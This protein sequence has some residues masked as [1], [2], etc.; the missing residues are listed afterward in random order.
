[1]QFRYFT[2]SLEGF[3]D[4]LSVMSPSLRREVCLHNDSVWINQVHML[5]GTG[6][7]FRVE[8]RAHA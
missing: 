1:V 6:D 5:R 8:V 3:H 7:D 2:P 4:I